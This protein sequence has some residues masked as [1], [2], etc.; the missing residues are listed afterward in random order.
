MNTFIIEDDLTIACPDLTKK[1]IDKEYNYRSLNPEWV[2]RIQKES[3]SLKGNPTVFLFKQDLLSST[4]SFLGEAQFRYSISLPQGGERMSAH[5]RQMMRLMEVAVAHP[6]HL[7]CFYSGYIA[8]KSKSKDQMADLSG[9]KTFFNYYQSELMGLKTEVSSQVEQDGNYERT[10]EI[11]DAVDD[12]VGQVD[13]KDVKDVLFNV[14]VGIS[15]CRG[16]DV[17][18]AC[19][20]FVLT[21][22]RLAYLNINKFID[23][24]INSPKN[25]DFSKKIR[26][27]FKD[28]VVKDGKTISSAVYK[29]LPICELLDWVLIGLSEQARYRPKLLNRLLIQ[30]K[31]NNV[32][33]FLSHLGKNFYIKNKLSRQTAK[34]L[35]AMLTKVVGKE[36]KNAKERNDLCA[37]F[38]LAATV[39][40]AV[41][42][43]SIKR[44]LN[45]IKQGS[46]Y[47]FIEMENP[48]LYQRNYPLNI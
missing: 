47:P 39:A 12:G 3:E 36:Y 20:A 22:G 34:E 41:L 16:E 17:V 10:K 14:F 45:G 28:G 9:A 24:S 42:I 6:Q 26:W 40:D 29:D 31:E 48:T 46:Y 30:L 1:E 38:G 13:F 4:E 5:Y 44:V 15:V 19:R 8:K 37:R 43:D 23:L 18:S 25:I 11:I 35:E 33:Y 27:I 21:R 7:Y 32:P 2:D